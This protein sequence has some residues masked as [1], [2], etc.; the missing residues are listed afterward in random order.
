VRTLEKHYAP[1][2]TALDIFSIRA[3]EVLVSG[4]AGTGKTRACLEK[5]NG[6]A[7]K[8]PGM[9][10]LIVRKTAR[11]LPSSCLAEFKANVIA[12]QLLAGDV[13][14]YGGSG[15]TPQGFYYG[16]GSVVEVG[17]MDNPTKIMSTQYDF[18]FVEEATEL[19]VEDWEALL[20]RLRNGVMPYQQLLGACNPGADTHFL[21]QRCNEGKCLLLSA[22]HEENPRLFDVDGNM[23]EYGRSYIEDGLDQLTGI[24]YK[25]YR[26]GL[27][28][29]AEG[30]IF[31]EFDR[32]IHVIPS[33]EIPRNWLRYWSVDFG[34]TNPLVVQMWAEDPEGRLYLYRELYHSKRLVEDVCT[35]LK[36]ILTNSKGEWLEPKPRM[37]IC[38]H[39]AEDRATFERHMGLGTL[40]ANKNVSVGLQKTAMRFRV[41]KDG[42]PRIFFFTDAL[43]ET[44]IRMVELKKPTC[45]VEE[46][47]G[48]IWA[49]R[50]EEPFKENDHGCDAMRYIVMERDLHGVTKVRFA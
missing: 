5:L 39:D 3:R 33:F 7:L 11:S 37:V 27:W 43:Y 2:G 21:K 17:G 26:K 22:R 12:E 36:G 6:V 30:Q 31:D 8:Y 29:G 19:T 18:V 46:I 41:Q 10:G 28:V 14:W 23:T 45:T 42:K 44:D 20:I 40:P 32:N 15:S 38:D 49:P 16:N 25:R 34:H 4:S 35:Q 13:K 48:Y 1:R 24:Y 47:P 9:R 50:K